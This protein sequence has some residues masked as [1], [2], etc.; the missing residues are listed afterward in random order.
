MRA[1]PGS[2]KDVADDLFAPNVAAQVK[3]EIDRRSTSRLSRQPGMGPLSHKT[4]WLGDFEWD[5]TSTGCFEGEYTLRAKPDREGWYDYLPDPDTPFQFVIDGLTV[6]P[7]AMDTD[8]GSIPKLFRQGRHLKPDTYLPAYL[9]HDWVFEDHHRRGDATGITFPQSAALLNSG[10]KTL[11]TVGGP[12]R[13]PDQEPSGG[14]VEKDEDT[15]FLI[16]LAVQTGIAR[17]LWDYG[18]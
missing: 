9:I 4:L 8:M 6:T 12:Y 13:I 10:I 3:A 7:Q 17:S 1:D 5:R 2:L 15:M 14:P 18:R 11:M 16:Y